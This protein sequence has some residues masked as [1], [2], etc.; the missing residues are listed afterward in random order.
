MALLKK[1]SFIPSEWEAHH[2]P[3]AESSMTALCEVLATVPR[4]GLDDGGDAVVKADIP[5]RV[6]QKNLG[7]NGETLSSE[8]ST[9]EYLV[10]MPHDVGINFKTGRD[11]HRVRITHANNERLVGRT[12]SVTQVMTGSLIWETDV[13]CEDNQTQNEV[14]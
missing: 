7:A 13:L 6:Q 3:V 11:G 10:T 5:C 4:T 1:R 12:L 14:S 9:R 8:R 2:R